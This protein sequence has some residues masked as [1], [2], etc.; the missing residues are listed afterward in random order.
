M[1]LVDERRDEVP[2]AEE[3]GQRE[4]EHDRNG[5]GPTTKVIYDATARFAQGSGRNENPNSISGCTK[6]I[7]R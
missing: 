5:N 1:F 7:P 2:E 4:A 6:R 3:K